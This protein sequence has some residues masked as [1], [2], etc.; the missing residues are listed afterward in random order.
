MCIGFFLSV[1]VLCGCADKEVVTWPETESNSS[2]FRPADTLDMERAFLKSGLVDAQ[3]LDPSIKVHLR[4]GTNDNFMGVNF[5]QGFNKCYLQP[6]VAQMLVQ[7]QQQLKKEHSGLTLLVWDAARPRSVQREMWRLTVPPHG[8][9]KALFVSNPAYGSLHNYGCAVDVTLAD[10]HGNL[11]DLG[12][13]FDHFG[14]E[15]WP[16]EEA[17]MLKVAKISLEQVTNRKILRSAM[18]AAGFWNIQTEWWHFNAMRREVAAARYTI[19]E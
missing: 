15:A 2:L 5:Y 6:L 10:Q 14:H 13:D 18:Y 9:S 1:V 8:V 12:T 7:A 19:L 16:V 11:L 4:Y 3:Q 17:K